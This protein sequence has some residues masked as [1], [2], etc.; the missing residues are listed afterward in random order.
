MQQFVDFWQERFPTAQIGVL[1]IQENRLR[2]HITSNYSINPMDDVL[3]P[4]LMKF[5]LAFEDE[6]PRLSDGLILHSIDGS[7]SRY[8]VSMT[9]DEMWGHRI[10][11]ISIFGV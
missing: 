7:V 6:C 10:V 11:N 2:L 3:V 1:E 4:A 8:Q 9:V 5:K